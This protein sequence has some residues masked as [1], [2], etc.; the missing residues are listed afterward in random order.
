MEE[1]VQKVLR[2]IEEGRPF[3]IWLHSHFYR[4]YIVALIEPENIFLFMG[5]KEGGTEEYI[6]RVDPGDIQILP[7]E[8]TP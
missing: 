1:Q 8:C 3:G 2:A 5:R 6:G 4:G 7:A